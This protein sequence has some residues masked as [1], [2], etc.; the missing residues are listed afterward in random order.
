[1][2][3]L[4]P[5]LIGSWNQDRQLPLALLTLHARIDVANLNDESA[6]GYPASERRGNHLERFKDL[7]L[8]AK[9][10]AV[11]YVPYSLDSGLNPKV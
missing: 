11:L 9:A 5:L 6:R 4:Q 8:K 2:G 7:N 3:G 10:L 1:M